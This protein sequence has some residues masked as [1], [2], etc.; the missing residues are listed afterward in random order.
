MLDYEIKE[1][2][3]VSHY[4]IDATRAKM[5][6]DP[7]NKF[8]LT[9]IAASHCHTERHKDAHAQSNSFLFTQ[10]GSLISIKFPD[11]EY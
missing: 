6:S 5:N 1:C 3:D 2:D 7:H 9:I 10:S 4:A 8:I 11:S